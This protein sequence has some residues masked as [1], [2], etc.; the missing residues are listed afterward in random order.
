MHIVLCC[1][2]IIKS[3]EMTGGSVEKVYQSLGPV[4]LIQGF[5]Q[6]GEMVWQKSREIKQCRVL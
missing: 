4:D 3:D 5:W 1:Y 6:N 2:F